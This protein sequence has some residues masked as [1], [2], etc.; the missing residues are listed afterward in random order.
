MPLVIINE[1]EIINNKIL[2]FSNMI[3]FGKVENIYANMGPPPNNNK[4]AGKAQHI[5]ILR[6]A[7]KL[8][9]VI[10]IIFIGCFLLDVKFIY[11]LFCIYDLFYDYYIN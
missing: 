4:S 5:H 10:K 1:P 6:L 3:N 2:Y 11:K 7:N 8:D 9:R